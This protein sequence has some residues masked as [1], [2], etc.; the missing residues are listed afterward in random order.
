MVKIIRFR[1]MGEEDLGILVDGYIAPF[2]EMELP[3]YI[4]YPLNIEPITIEMLKNLSPEDYLVY[5]IEEVDILPPIKYPGKII[6]LG[7]NYKSHVLE[8]GREMPSD[9]VIFMKPRTSVAGPYDIID[10]PKIIKQL[11]YEG[12][13][14]IVVGRRGRFIG[15]EEAHNYI[16]GYMI[17]NDLSARD[18]QFSDGQWTRGKGF[19]GFAPIGPWIVTLDE[20]GDPHKLR[21]RTWVNDELRQDGSTSEMIFKIP[22]IVSRVSM[23]MTLEPGDIISTGT[24]AGVGFVHGE[25]KLLKDGDKVRIEIEGIGFIENTVRF[26]DV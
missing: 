3:P 14:A 15:V 20:I 8:T 25:D 21:I 12:E 17:M 16:L 2:K 4:E 5:D 11:D 26:I 24:P 23:V 6:C 7:L 19:D 13:L 1:I 9:I 18:F 22:E 10:V